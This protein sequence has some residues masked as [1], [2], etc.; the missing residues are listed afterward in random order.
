M[1][2]LAIECDGDESH[3]PDRWQHDM[4]RQRILERAVAI[5]AVL[6]LHLDL[7]PRRSS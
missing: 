6:C 5:F 1:P 4:N 2:E 7:A 3:G